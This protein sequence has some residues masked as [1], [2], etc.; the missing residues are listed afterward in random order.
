MPK[1]TMTA[2]TKD[3]ARAGRCDHIDLMAPQVVTMDEQRARIEPSAR[4]QLVNEVVDLSHDL[5]VGVSVPGPQARDADTLRRVPPDP[6]HCRPHSPCRRRSQETRSHSPRSGSGN[7]RI[8]RGRGS[9]T[10]LPTAALPSESTRA[11]LTTEQD[12]PPRET[13]RGE[14]CTE[15]AVQVHA[16]LASSLLVHARTSS[17]QESAWLRRAGSKSLLGAQHVAMSNLLAEPGSDRRGHSRR[18]S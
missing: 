6:L 10:P 12:P 15:R 17:T 9:E 1:P 2:R 5:L 16:L 11:S 18:P 3:D 8:R 7:Q 4:K 14:L 13:T